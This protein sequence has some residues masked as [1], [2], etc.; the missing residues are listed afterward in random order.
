MLNIFLQEQV[1]IKMIFILDEKDEAILNNVK[2]LFGFGKVT[3]R[4]ETLYVY[5]Y[6]YRISK[7]ESYKIIF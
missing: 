7:Y 3:I 2:D 6:S 4:S 1:V 5:I